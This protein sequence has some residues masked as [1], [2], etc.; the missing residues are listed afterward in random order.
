MALSEY[1]A[2]FDLGGRL[3]FS[4]E[5]KMLRQTNMAALSEKPLEHSVAE[6]VEATVSRA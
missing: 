2:A 6:I 3:S 5:K 4:G 1:V